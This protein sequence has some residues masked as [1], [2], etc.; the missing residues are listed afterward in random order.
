MN[1]LPKDF[2]EFRSA[3]Y[4]DRFFKERGSKAFEWYGEWPQ[5]RNLALP[6]C[7]GKSV[8]VVGCGNSEMSAEMY[9]DG[10]QEITNIDFS[11][12]VV[13]E[14]LLKN[15]RERPKMKWL[16]MD[17]TETKFD[18]GSFSVVFDKGGLDALMGEENE[19]SEKAGGKLLAEVARIL[20]P[21][22]GVY[23]CV[24]L[25]QRQVLRR[26]L[27]SFLKGW[28]ISIHNVAPSSDMALSPLHPYVVV[29]KREWSDSNQSI[30]I[31]PDFSRA[32]Y[33]TNSEQV[34]DIWE[35]VD[36]ENKARS[37]GETACSDIGVPFFDFDEIHP[38]R[39][40]SI[41]LPFKS[42]KSEKKYQAVVID[43]PSQNCPSVCMVFIVPQGKESEWLYCNPEGQRSV[44]S[45]CKAQRVIL[46]SLAPGHSAPSMKVL[47]EELSGLVADLIP[48]SVR[49][50]PK[51]VP[52]VTDS[53][54]I[55]K[56]AVR[57]RV[58]SEISGQV[59]VED[60]EV[61]GDYFR[62]LVF[63][64]SRSLIQS[65]AKLGT[66]KKIKGDAMPAL[67]N[68]SILHSILPSDY[69][70][71]IVSGLSWLPKLQAKIHEPSASI[72]CRGIV[73]GLGGGGLPLFL[74]SNFELDLEVIELDP[75]VV[76][77]AEKWFEFEEKEGLRLHVGDG[78]ARIS[79][80]ASIQDADPLDFI[81]LDAGGADDS[82]SMSCPPG[83][84]LEEPF[85]INARKLME[86]SL[87]GGMLIINFVVR[88]KDVYQNAL[89]SVWKVFPHMKEIDI[90]GDVNRIVFAF[91]TDPGSCGGGSE[92][93]QKCSK[94]GWE[95]RSIDV[96]DILK[97][98]NDLSL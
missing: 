10:V 98:L 4:W 27:G 46:I 23:I 95:D 63:G 29:V 82:Q 94:T 97:D 83:V 49:F 39:M 18:D 60:V 93:L 9:D 26:L 48:L 78:I 37:R 76:D 41:S 35:I 25:A 64:S 84:F 89:R 21:A 6:L 33:A 13:R 57:A 73:V 59:V 44:A 69:H 1:L 81:I 67:S 88:S 52:Y 36:A 53:D 65:E 87:G 50:Q 42:S 77:V 38:K 90:D 85:L 70:Q 24:T 11:K 66:K 43:A 58:T 68:L 80:L 12:V 92:V 71:A 14:M 47:Q 75:A 17:M 86:K 55:G 16:V 5:L 32:C 51:A 56:M 61:K 62:R 2:D 74:H 8:L 22:T 28:S 72:D 45:Q 91:G 40:C 79:E 19:A 96:D 54:G 20:N 30:P 15:V 34:A 31:S 3:E 7:K